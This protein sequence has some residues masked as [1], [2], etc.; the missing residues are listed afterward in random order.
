MLKNRHNE[1]KTFF[2][3]SDF[4]LTR[5]RPAPVLTR[6]K[7]TEKTFNSML[8]EYYFLKLKETRDQ[9]HSSI[10]CSSG[11]AA[12]LDPVDCKKWQKKV[13]TKKLVWEIGD[14]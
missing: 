6:S 7:K 11:L 10:H 14:L 5:A 3:V 4:L 2:E 13:P 12:T 9:K 1:A 8:L